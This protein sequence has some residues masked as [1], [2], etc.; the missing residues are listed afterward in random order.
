MGKK[1]HCIIRKLIRCSTVSQRSF[2]EGT[3]KE[4]VDGA[5]MQSLLTESCSLEGIQGLKMVNIIGE[6]CRSVLIGK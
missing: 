4:D 3:G 6:I 5:I 1:Y 2:L